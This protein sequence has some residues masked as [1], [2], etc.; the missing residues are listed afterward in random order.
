M[1]ICKYTLYQAVYV[2]MVFVHASPNLIL[3]LNKKLNLVYHS[4]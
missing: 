3:L 2:N 1:Y 4:L